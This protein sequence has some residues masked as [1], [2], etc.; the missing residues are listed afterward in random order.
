MAINASAPGKIIL[1]GEHS[2]VYGYPAIAAAV[3]RRIAIYKSGKVESDIPIGA[4]MGSSAAYAV[5]KS[6]L[7]IGKPDLERINRLAYEMEKK[8]HGSPS[9]VDNTVVT[10]GGFLWYRKE[11]E[12]FKT[13]RQIEAKR[14]LPKL[15][16]FNSG[17]PAESTKDM[18]EYVADLRRKRKIYIEGI[19]RRIEKV[20]RG[21]LSY[22][23]EEANENFGHLIRENGELLESLGV[24]SESTKTIIKRVEEMGGYAK[25][26][27]AGGR[28]VGSGM[29]LVYYKDVEKI[30]LFRKNNK[31]NIFP[32]E[33][34]GEGVRI[35][36]KK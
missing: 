12:N 16:L 15:F 34:G 18:V 25:I 5:A 11:S 24:V 28:R 10:Y 8:R 22:L 3:D 32:V 27:G 33:L 7:K 4:G 29:V 17:K 21:F 6:A 31:L 30:S 20:T 2:V 1:S 36:H 26:I 13:F 35:Q 23:T 14:K 19:F 9:G